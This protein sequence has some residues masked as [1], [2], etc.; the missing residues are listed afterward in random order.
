MQRALPLP[1]TENLKIISSPAFFIWHVGQLVGL[2]H[3]PV[4]ALPVS[5][6]RLSDVE[7]WMCRLETLQPLYPLILTILLNHFCNFDFS[8]GHT[9][10]VRLARYQTY[11][12]YR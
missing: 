3:I 11:L 8:V 1:A 6:T 4:I 12:S 10:V 9:T 5:T 2:L 7:G